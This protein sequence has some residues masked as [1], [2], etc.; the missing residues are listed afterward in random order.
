MIS[1]CQHGMRRR[2]F[3]THCAPA[4]RHP[5]R[6][7]LLRGSARVCL[8]R[9][10]LTLHL[11][12]DLSD[13]EK[14]TRCRRHCLGRLLRCSRPRRLTRRPP[15]PT[16]ALRRNVL[17]ALRAAFVGDAID[18]LRVPCVELAHRRVPVALVKL[19]CRLRRHAVWQVDTHDRASL[20]WQKAQLHLVEQHL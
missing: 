7:V 5:G 18:G 20:G 17:V 13:K 4:R 15:L 3:D 1:L 8:A 9:K 6:P 16:R 12:A 14:G 2:H 11:E 10:R 19:A